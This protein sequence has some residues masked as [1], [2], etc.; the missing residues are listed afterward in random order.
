MGKGKTAEEAVGVWSR[1]VA[2]CFC[3]SRLRMVM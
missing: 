1:K 3:D 2:K